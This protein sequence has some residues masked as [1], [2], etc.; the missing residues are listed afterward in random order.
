VTYLQ[1]TA[2]ALIA[3]LLVSLAEL[4][5]L[6]LL[7]RSQLVGAWELRRAVFSLAPLAWLLS[8]PVTL[9][10]LGLLALV[11]HAAHAAR[12]RSAAALMMFLAGAGATY[13]VTFGRHFKALWLRLSL[14]TVVACCVGA[15]AF[16]LAPK[17][18]RWARQFP[19]MTAL[20]A[21]LLIALLQLANVFLFR[22][23]YPGFHLSLTLACWMIAPAI[24]LL[25]APPTPAPRAPNRTSNLLALVPICIPLILLPFTPYL[26]RRLAHAEN[27]RF[28]F[29][30]HSPSLRYAVELATKL[31]PSTNDSN[32]PLVRSADGTT[33]QFLDF[34]GKD[35]LL[36]TVDALRADH[37]SS[38]GYPRKTT[39]EIDKLVENGTSFTH[40]YCATPHTSYSISSIMTGKYMRPLLLQN[41]GNDSDT[42]AK[43]L[44]T[45]SYRTAAF[46]PPAVFFIDR[47]RFETFD[48][49]GFD[50]EY[51]RVEF[52]PAHQRVT[53]IK[54]YLDT[55]RPEHRTM[56]WVHLF[57]PHEPYEAH[58]EYAFGTQDMD[59]YDSEIA[60]T[61]AA[62]GS[63]VREFR[64]QRPNSVIILSADHGEEFSEHGGRYHGSSVYEEQVRVPLIFNAP[65][66]IPHQKVTQPVQTI[67]IL[68]TI[69]AGL[70]IPRPA[71]VR[72]KDLGRWMVQSQP[73]TKD[74]GFAFAETDESTMLAEGN[75]RLVCVRRAGACQL[76]DVQADPG[77]TK[78][79]SAM[80]MDTFNRL[81]QRLK[82]VESA[83]GKFELAG[84]RAEG[85][86]WPEP[87]RRGISG[88][89]DAAIDIAA[90][91][92]DADVNFRR[93][94][95]ELLFELKRSE[96]APALRL[97]LRRDEDE[98]VKRWTS[99][100]LTRLGEGTGKSLELIKDKDI[101]WRRLAALAFAETGDK[102]GESIL[103]AWFRAG[104]LDFERNSQIVRAMGK[105]KSKQAVYPLTKRLDDIRLRPIIAETLGEIGE[106]AARPALLKQFEQER[107]HP[108][109]QILGA[110]MVKLG[111]G[112]E[113][114]PSIIRFLGVPDPM[115][116]ALELA[117]KG[118]FVEF[119]GGPN[120]KGQRAIHKL[121]SRTIAMPIFVPKR[122]ARGKGIR[123]V[124]RA[125][126]HRELGAVIKVGVPVPVQFTGKVEDLPPAELDPRTATDIAVPKSE[127]YHQY[128]IT[129]PE[130]L[131]IKA[132]H[133]FILAIH[134]GTDVEISSL[135]VVPL[136]SD[137]EP[138]KPKP[139]KSNDKSNL[140]GHMKDLV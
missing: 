41:T 128:M 75:F 93:K 48:K 36:I 32:L 5:V 138:P 72:G 4:F 79:V 123:L 129:F 105:I 132:G 45:Y 17:L 38:F 100:A 26:A 83:H 62:I 88:D 20:G 43:L 94:A 121:A 96:T 107:Y 98:A 110:T 34:S 31:A 21:A 131:K 90:L 7:F 12:A 135:A 122:K 10:G 28:I 15:A 103:V 65:G 35:I 113:L 61:D 13:S 57:E 23:L 40:T 11:W 127:Q 114:A 115:P 97:A 6:L 60:A 74:L 27:L 25:W 91:L 104:H 24:S 29:S 87:I 106:E 70:A 112:A 19:S 8:L 37:L 85:R 117:E 78:N 68:P 81:R 2:N 30:E 9:L 54:T 67:D 92:D 77:E 47:E 125:R 118:E 139:G 66:T 80:H 33:Q 73:T 95:A 140:P 99:L 39:P 108:I 86:A 55:L 84:L 3:A 22:R 51:R 59:R 69:L 101:A 50:F 46:Y 89:G 111:A 49:S 76:F 53:E 124:I 16:F 120:E 42:L 18:S 136:Q 14:M 64:K 58:P 82:Q 63:I 126:S 71:R 56:L 1:R 137:F 116:N 119:I 109:R 134:R 133:H 52:V 44:R 102:R 130:S